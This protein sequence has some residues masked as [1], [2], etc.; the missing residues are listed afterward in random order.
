M[1]PTVPIRTLTI[2]LIAICG[3]VISP[4]E[5]HSQ[6]PTGP[7]F[8]SASLRGTSWTHQ[9]VNQYKRWTYTFT[10]SALLDSTYYNLPTHQSVYVCKR[11][12]YL[13]DTIPSKFDFTQVGKITTG[14]YLVKWTDG[15]FGCNLIKCLDEN[16]L[17]FI[18]PIYH[19]EIIYFKNK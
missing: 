2:L 5:I 9:H 12:Y 13:S 8:S 10:D 3:Q 1:K 7:K 15:N 16:K 6:T 17:S 18:H 4:S 19:D 14:Y 11:Y